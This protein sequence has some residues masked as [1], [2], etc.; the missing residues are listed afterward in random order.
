MYWNSWRCYPEEMFW[1]YFVHVKYWIISLFVHV[2]WG[3]CYV[4]DG[5]MF[6]TVTNIWIQEIYSSLQNEHIVRNFVSV[7]QVF[8]IFQLRNAEMWHVKIFFF[9]IFY[10]PFF[11]CNKKFICFLF[12]CTILLIYIIS[13][14][15][16][17]IIMLVLV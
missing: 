14:N 1:I 12:R 4:V 10:L 9:F 8:M 7:K 15:I 16:F 3:V 17:F 2:A 11:W 13:T 5:A 6:Y